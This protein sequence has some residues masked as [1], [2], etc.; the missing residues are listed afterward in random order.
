MTAP[1]SNAKRVATLVPRSTLSVAANAGHYTFLAACTEAGRASRPDL[2]A[3]E[4][5]VNRQAV[6]QHAVALA[7]DFFGRTL[8]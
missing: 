6:H 5:G 8:K 4:R 1:D 2:C 3:D 7:V